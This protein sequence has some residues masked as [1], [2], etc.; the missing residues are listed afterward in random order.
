L[1]KST[2]FSLASFSLPPVAFRFG[3]CF[4]GC[5]RAGTMGR[6]ATCALGSGCRAW[7]AAG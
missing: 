7:R 6:C 3:S 5:M 2:G 1:G 4:T